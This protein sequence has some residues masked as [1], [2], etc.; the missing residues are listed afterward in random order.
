MLQVAY[1]RLEE[2]RAAFQKQIKEQSIFTPFCFR[3]MLI[4]SRLNIFQASKMREIISTLTADVDTLTA[5]LEREFEDVGKD[6]GS[7]ARTKSVRE[8]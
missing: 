3:L 4:E 6:N 5:K 2:R 7:A 8:Q 1:R